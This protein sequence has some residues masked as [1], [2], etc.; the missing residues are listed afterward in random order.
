MAIGTARFASTCPRCGQAISPGDSITWQRGQKASHTTC[1]PAPAPVAPATD[2]A[3]EAIWSSPGRGR[4]V[5]DRP[6]IGRAILVGDGMVEITATRRWISRGDAEDFDW[7]D[8]SE[9]GGGW[10]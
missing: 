8:V 6:E 2:E 10:L 3:A 1:R 7:F 5:Y 4:I 9:R